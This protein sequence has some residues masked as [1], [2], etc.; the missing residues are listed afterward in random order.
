MLDLQHKGIQTALTPA[1]EMVIKYSNIFY[2]YAVSIIYI[3]LQS[4]VQMN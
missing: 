2:L 1:L 4:D 3:V